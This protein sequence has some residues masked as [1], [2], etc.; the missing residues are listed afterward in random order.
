MQSN[1]IYLSVLKTA[2][3]K[4]L[5]KN[6]PQILDDAVQY[7]E[8]HDIQVKQRKKRSKSKPLQNIDELQKKT[9][10]ASAKKISRL[11]FSI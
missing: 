5:T 8:N 2:I 11:L 4:A 6:L 7:L 1:Q 10:S 9:Q 3:Q